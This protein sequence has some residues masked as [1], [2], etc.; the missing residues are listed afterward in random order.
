MACSGWELR[1]G[2]GCRAVSTG[3]WGFLGFPACRWRVRGW[4]APSAPCLRAHSL[5][6]SAAVCRA[7]PQRSS[8]GGT[9]AGNSLFSS[10]PTQTKR[11]LETCLGRDHMPNG[12]APSC[13]SSCYLS[14]PVV[15]GESARAHPHQREL[16]GG[17][18]P[19]QLVSRLECGGAVRI[20][21]GSQC[22]WVRGAVA[23]RYLGVVEGFWGEGRTEQTG[24]PCFTEDVWDFVPPTRLGSC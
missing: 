22:S 16:A 19:A 7:C 15:W 6:A 21:C 17:A 12:L 13:S 5:E 4:G 1:A 18:G 3:I 2:T 9:T 14:R 23:L 10:R 11:L 20:G 8:R 24:R